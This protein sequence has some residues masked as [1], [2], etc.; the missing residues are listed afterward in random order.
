MSHRRLHPASA[1]PRAANWF[2]TTTKVA[3]RV[4]ALAGTGD[5]LLS[6]SQVDLDA[7]IRRD[8]RDG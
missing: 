7:A 5:I 4:V 2:A 6:A 1:V 8:G 3:A